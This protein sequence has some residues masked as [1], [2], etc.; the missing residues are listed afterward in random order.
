VFYALPRHGAK[1]P[2]VPSRWNHHAPRSTRAG[3]R[4]EPLRRAGPTRRRAPRR[5]RRH[6]VRAPE[7]P[8]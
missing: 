1:W 6:H 4:H 2:V 7:V 8:M 5:L 3:P